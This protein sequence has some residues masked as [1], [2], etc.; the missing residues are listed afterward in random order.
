MLRF[1]G[2]RVE[3]MHAS[4]AGLPGLSRE[5]IEIRRHPQWQQGLRRR[6]CS[7]FTIRLDAK[8]RLRFDYGWP[9]NA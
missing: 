3:P 5:P 8:Q 9:R 1:T 4:G 7:D 6:S 2:P